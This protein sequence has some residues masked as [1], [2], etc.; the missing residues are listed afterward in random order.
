MVQVNLG[1]WFLQLMASNGKQLA[2]GTY[3]TGTPNEAAG[4]GGIS[5]SGPGG[6]C[7]DAHSTFTIYQ[8]ALNGGYLSQL[9][10]S[11]SQ[12]CGPSTA[13]PLVGF[14]RFNATQPTPIPV[15][16]ASS[17]SQPGASPAP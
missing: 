4:I 8:I 6:A 1:Q 12:S 15:L 3:V 9:N 10:A 7:E 5:V 17:W 11:F 13:P 16:P 2:P 14:I